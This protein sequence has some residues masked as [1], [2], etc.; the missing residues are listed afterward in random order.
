MNWNG[1]VC[2][3][4]LWFFLF[5]S[6]NLTGFFIPIS[7]VVCSIRVF[8]RTYYCVLLCFIFLPFLFLFLHKFTL[9]SLP[10]PTNLPVWFICL[11]VCSVVFNQPNSFGNF[12]LP[13]TFSRS[14]WREREKLLNNKP[15]VKVCL[16]W[17][18]PLPPTSW[19]I[20]ELSIFSVDFC[21]CFEEK[22]PTFF[23]CVWKLLQIDY[24]HRHAVS[25]SE[26]CVLLKVLSLS[27]SLPLFFF[28]SLVSN[29]FKAR[30]P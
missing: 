9:F 23:F 5:D 6:Q 1:S 11:F 24:C 18:L 22:S 29:E 21:T 20:F 25:I 27:H 10:L 17:K 16:F 28:F 12:F 2:G 19:L 14:S 13:E 7:I 30:Q 4:K 26:K 3:E 15:T 8:S